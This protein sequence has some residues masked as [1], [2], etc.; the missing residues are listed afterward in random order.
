MQT[1]EDHPMPGLSMMLLPLLAAGSMHGAP[2]YTV[3]AQDGMILLFD[4][5]QAASS[6][7]TRACYNAVGS[8]DAYRK[9]VKVLSKG[10][11]PR[12][13]TETRKRFFGRVN[14][15]A[16]VAGHY[17]YNGVPVQ[18]FCERADLVVIKSVGP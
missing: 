7:D 12:L 17:V 10:H 9:I 4:N 1:D 15:S 18:D 16:D 13:A 14:W 8:P 3:V 5:A 6:L 2:G 11:S